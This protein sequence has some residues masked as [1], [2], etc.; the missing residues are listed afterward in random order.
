M[1]S[2]VIVG[3]W[4]GDG[5]KEDGIYMP[6][7]LEL[8]PDIVECKDITRQRLDKGLPEVNAVLFRVLVP[9]A[10]ADAMVAAGIV[11]RDG[12]KA[13]GDTQLRAKLRR[14]G[15]SPG[16]AATRDPKRMAELLKGKERKSVRP[17]SVEGRRSRVGPGPDGMG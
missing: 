11:L 12:N 15:L 6:D 2:L 14:L 7:F 9:D 1:R 13:V 10:T 8:Y 3:E 17:K 4:T 5:T 16:E